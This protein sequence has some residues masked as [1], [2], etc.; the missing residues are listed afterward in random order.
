[1]GNLTLFLADIGEVTTVVISTFTD[2]LA[3][4][5]EPPLV[6]FVA[7]GFITAIIYIAKNMIRQT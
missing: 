4:F 5:M 1:M 2:I 3:I 6:V 7:L